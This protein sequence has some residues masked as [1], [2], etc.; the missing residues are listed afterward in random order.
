MQRSERTTCATV[1]CEACGKRAVRQGLEFV[2]WIA[3]VALVLGLRIAAVLLAPWKMEFAV[4]ARDLYDQLYPQAAAEADADTLGWLAAA[5]FGYQA[6]LFP[7]PIIHADLVAL[8]ALAVTHEQR[9]AAF[10][11][12]ALGEVESFRDAQP[13]TPQYDDQAAHPITVDASAGVAH[14]SNDFLNPR[15]I[16]PG[17][18]DL[19]Y[20]AGALRGSREVSRVSVADRRRPEEVRRSFSPPICRVR[21]E[22]R[23]YH[24]RH[25]PASRPAVCRRVSQPPRGRLSRE[26]VAGWFLPGAGWRRNAE[27]L[28]DLACQS[29]GDLTVPRDRGRPL[30]ASPQKLWLAPSRRRRAP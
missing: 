17:S 6:L 24:A 29:E 10:V 12:I 26:A 4:D 20:V 22:D 27:V 16:R 3:L 13:S 23:V 28:T 18:A 5:G 15:G 9:S 30:G 8:A 2:G 1:V 25:P 19:C 14:H 7:T 21:T 11:E